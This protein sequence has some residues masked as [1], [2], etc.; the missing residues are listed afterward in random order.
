MGI[1]ALQLSELHY[2][3]KLNKFG[4]GFFLRLFREDQPGQHLSIDLVKP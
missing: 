4:S 1:S 3:C 2:A